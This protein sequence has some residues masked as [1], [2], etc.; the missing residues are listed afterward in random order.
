MYIMHIPHSIHTYLIK[1]THIL[2]EA[3]LNRETH[4]NCAYRCYLFKNGSKPIHTRTPASIQTHR[5]I[6]R[7]IP[8][9]CHAIRVHKARYN[10]SLQCKQILKRVKEVRF[11]RAL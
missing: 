8:S 5:H 11:L 9:H 6:R 10:L 4:T 1:C 7:N 2:Y 3:K